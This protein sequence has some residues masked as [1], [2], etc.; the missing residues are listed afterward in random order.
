MNNFTLPLGID[1]L[2]ITAQ[3]IDRKGNIIFD[4]KSTKRET[5]C[6][7]CGQLTKNK[8][9]YGETLTVRHVSILDKP[10]YLRIRVVRYQCMDCDDHP[11]TSEKYDWMER[12]SKTT[13]ELDA[14][15]NR[16]LIHST[17]E[18]VSKKERVTYDIVESSLNRC[19][20]KK[21]NWVNF[22]DLT[23]I[24]IDEIALKK[25]QND[26]VVIVSTQDKHGNL[27]VIGVLPDRLKE[28]TKT[29]LESIPDDLKKTIKSV[30]TD[31]CD[32]FVNS[33]K[34]VFGNRVVVI[35]RFHVAKLYREPLD[36]L[37]M[38]EM[39]RLKNELSDEE[40]HQLE[41]VM[42]II[43]KQHECLSKGDKAKLDFLYKHSPKL[44]KAH[45][46]ALKL[47]NIFNTHQNR[48]MAF[49]K[50]NR[51]TALVKKSD[52]SC[53]NSFIKTLEKYKTNV[54]NYFKRRK[55][56][57]FVE[58]L[59]NKIKV[60]KRRCYGLYKTESIFQRLFLDLLGYKVFA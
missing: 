13:K 46:L 37:R 1:S 6:H 40:Y 33:A 22:E 16:Q 41:N 23:T 60:M 38:Q 20:D 53:F 51:W 19:V 14:Y 57:G 28:T 47:T 54:L 43:R 50:I 48:K 42:W 5:P 25:G 12:K 9:G 2:E 26:Y 17:V 31:M 44:K 3:T 55:T 58:G 4:V 24:G 39:K 15:I 8:Y 56:S 29:F 49:T 18:D 10:V 36:R 7:K 32:S 45:K 30:C 27:A 35:D 11:T 52:V 21:V 59:N 34:E